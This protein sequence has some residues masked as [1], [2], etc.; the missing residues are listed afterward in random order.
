MSRCKDLISPQTI[1]VAAAR[2]ERNNLQFRSFLKN[3]A[4]EDELDQQFLEMHRELVATYDCCQCANCCRAY[5]TIVEEQ[6]IESIA[7]Y[8]GMERQELVDTYLVQDHGSFLLQAP[9]PFLEQDGTCRVRCA[10]QKSVGI[11]HTQTSRDDCTVCMACC[12]LQ[13]NAL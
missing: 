7:V 8:L 2:L 10:N 4:D 1:H 5:S 11:S 9:C 6:E 12:L 13:R 3:H